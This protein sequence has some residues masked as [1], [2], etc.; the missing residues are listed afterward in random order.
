MVGVVRGLPSYTTGSSTLA[1]ALDVRIF[2]ESSE[3]RFTG[4]LPTR[5]AITP[6]ATTLP[7]PVAACFSTS[8]SVGCFTVF[9]ELP[10]RAFQATSARFSTSPVVFTTGGH[11]RLSIPPPGRTISSSSANNPELVRVTMVKRRRLPI[12]PTGH[13][14]VYTVARCL[15]GPHALTPVRAHSYI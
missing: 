8:R 6:L 12:H 14:L 9:M 1:A 10:A 2:G 3:P 4:C 5:H 15:S 13:G 11:T 7:L